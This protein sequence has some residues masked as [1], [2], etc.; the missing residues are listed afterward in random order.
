MKF[1]T[2]LLGLV[3]AAIGWLEPASDDTVD[4]LSREGRGTESV[5]RDIVGSVTSG[6][7]SEGAHFY[8][9]QPERAEVV[10]WVAELAPFDP[11]NRTS[12]DA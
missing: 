2:V 12:Q 5:E 4:I 7:S 3:G 1:R 10:G 8:T 9:W 11:P 6:Y